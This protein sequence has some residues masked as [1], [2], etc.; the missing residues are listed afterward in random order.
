MPDKMVPDVLATCGFLDIE[1]NEY[2]TEIV[3]FTA[4]PKPEIVE[5]DPDGYV[6]QEDRITELEESLDLLLSGATE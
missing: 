5:E 2:G 4:L 3:S 6:S 1:L